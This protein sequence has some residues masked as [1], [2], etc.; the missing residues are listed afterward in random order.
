MLC[1][2]VTKFSV[3]SSVLQTVNNRNSVAHWGDQNVT[4][5]FTSPGDAASF[6]NRSNHI[7]H[8]DV[9]EESLLS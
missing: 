4:V 3:H 8:L 2:A 6:V 1:Y 5:L 9:S 7:R